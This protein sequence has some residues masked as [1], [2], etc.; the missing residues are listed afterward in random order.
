MDFTVAPPDGSSNHCDPAHRP[1]QRLNGE[2]HGS[3]SLVPL[4]V[5]AR[6]HFIGRDTTRPVP[7]HRLRRRRDHAAKARRFRGVDDWAQAATSTRLSVA[8][9]IWRIVE[10]LASSRFPTSVCFRLLRQAMA[11]VQVRLLVAW[12]TLVAIG[13]TAFAELVAQPAS[14]SHTGHTSRR[15]AAS[16]NIHS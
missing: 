10:V 9:R 7:K 6:L 15:H 8:S 13:D 3:H 12:G 16:Q 4:L 11:P 14:H 1:Y 2:T 5:S